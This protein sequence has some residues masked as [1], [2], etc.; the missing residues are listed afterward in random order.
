VPSMTEGVAG[1]GGASGAAL[2]EELA[3][4]VLVDLHASAVAK[5]LTRA[6]ARAR[7]A[8]VASARVERNRPGGV[9]LAFL[10]HCG[11]VAGVRRAAVCRRRLGRS[12]RLGRRVGLG[13]GYGSCGSRRGSDGLRG[14]RR[15]A[16]RG[17]RFARGGAQGEGQQGRADT[18]H[19]GAVSRGRCG[20]KWA[21]SG[22][23]LAAWQRAARAYVTLERIGG[24]P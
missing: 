23:T 14:G 17:R 6:V 9:L 5:Q 24:L 10:L 11:L 13:D 16:V 7:A 22:R 3:C 2:L 19:E 4:A 18:R 8:E 21:V 12:G 1:G 20:G 15:R